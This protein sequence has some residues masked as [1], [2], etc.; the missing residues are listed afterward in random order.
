MSSRFESYRDWEDEFFESSSK[1]EKKP[2]VLVG[3]LAG[4][5]LVLLIG[6]LVASLLVLSL[7]VGGWDDALTFKQAFGIGIAYASIRSIDT[8]MF[9]KQ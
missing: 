2:S 3:L 8:A 6:V 7:R 9:K 1:K 4:F 5:F